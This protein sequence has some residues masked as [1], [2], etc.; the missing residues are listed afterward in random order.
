MSKTLIV[1]LVLFVM[2]GG[3]CLLSLMGVSNSCVAQE[4]GID[5][6]YE[7][8]KVALAGYT[9]KILDMVQVPK[10]AK[11]HILEITTAA[12]QGRYGQNGAQAIFHAVKEQNPSVDPQIYRTLMQAMEAGRNGFDADQAVLLDKC[13]VYKTYYMQFPN[14]LIAGWMGFP[15]IDQTKCKPVITEQT[16]TDFKNKRTGPLQLE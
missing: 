16:E 1:L 7:K 9:N 14:S 8:N 11:S 2:L 10:M 13:R 3:S 12:I 15:K 5:A 4:N 6:Q